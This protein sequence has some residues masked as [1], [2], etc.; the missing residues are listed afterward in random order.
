MV[1]VTFPVHCQD[2]EVKCIA[3]STIF[4]TGPCTS[5][6]SDIFKFS[7]DSGTLRSKYSQDENLDNE[8]CGL[9]LSDL[10]CDQ[11]KSAL[12]IRSTARIH[13]QGLLIISISHYSCT[14]QLDGSVAH[15]APFRGAI[16]A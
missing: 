8:S 10:S 1:R 2:G 14:V 15:N 11:V 9:T 7:A 6:W 5:T 3:N 12:A 13:N 4:T 16:G